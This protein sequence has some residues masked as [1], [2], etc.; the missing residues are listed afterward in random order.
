[1]DPLKEGFCEGILLKLLFE[2]G[3]KI[4]MTKVRGWGLGE[5]EAKNSRQEIAGERR[6]GALGV[7][8]HQMRRK[9]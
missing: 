5:K 9:K 7:E 1:M 8:R 4:S 3:G 2:R 6:P